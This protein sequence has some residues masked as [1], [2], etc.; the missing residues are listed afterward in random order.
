M[1]L[2]FLC[3]KRCFKL[4][5]ELERIKWCKQFK[6]QHEMFYMSKKFN[7]VGLREIDLILLKFEIKMYKSTKH[8]QISILHQN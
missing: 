7:T 5:F 3:V 4:A 8:K 2:I 6:C 1:K